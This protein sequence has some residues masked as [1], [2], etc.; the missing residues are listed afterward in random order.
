MAR[1]SL[2]LPTQ[3]KLEAEKWA[4]QQGVSLNQFILWAVSE[5][6][7]SLGN[8]LDDERFPLITYRTGASGQPTAVIRSTNIRVQT[9]VVLHN[10]WHD[11]VDTI[12]D[13]YDLSQ[14][15]VEAAL[16]FYSEHQQEIDMNIAAEAALEDKHALSPT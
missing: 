1:Y 11:S 14:A 10:Q 16:A 5:K 15:Q 12:A 7:S 6:V 13:N 8:R 2:N 3:L 4:K 9:I